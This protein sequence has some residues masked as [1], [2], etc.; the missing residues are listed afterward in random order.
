MK[1]FLIFLI[2]LGFITPTLA[3]LAQEKSI[4]IGIGLGLTRGM[5][6]GKQDE[7]TIGPL[8]GLYGLFTNGLGNN[9]TPEF[10]VSYYMNGTSS[11]GGYSQYKATHITPELRLRYSFTQT[12][13]RPFVFAGIGAMIYSETEHPTNPDPQ[14]K[15]S[16]VALSIPLGVG[17]TWAIAEKLSLDF[18]AYANL[19]TT[20]NLNTVW[21]DINDANWVGRLGIHYNIA[22]I[23]KDSDGDG[24]S[25]KYEAQIGTDPNNPDTDGDGLKDGEEVN[26]YKTDPLNPDTDGGGIKDG[27]EV[28]NGADP[29]DADD[30]IMSIPVGGKII[31]KNIT[32]ET[33]K[34]KITPSSEKILNLALKALNSAKGMELQIVGHTDDVGSRDNNLI[35]SKERAEA[36]KAWLVNKG[37]EPSRLT[38][39]GKGPDEP[40]VPNTTDAN[41]QKNRRVEFFRSK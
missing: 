18:T 36:V 37:I 14:S 5:N 4:A 30:D 39:D 1:K 9:L 7:R 40:I 25:D 2:I 8:F 26:K 27:V 32:F 35:L 19:T 11:Y 34:A 17:F 10:S 3:T 20:D 29:L 22:N 12:D 13:F 15:Q 33:A 28:L 6:E 23:E 41:K 16:G 38:T 31:L 21:D 24:L